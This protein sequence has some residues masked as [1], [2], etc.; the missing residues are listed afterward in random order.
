MCGRFY[1]DADAEFLL[2]YYRIQYEPRVIVE[3][4]IIYPTQS[5]PV[6]I[7][8]QGERRLGT[9]NWGFKIPGSTKPIINSRAETI[10]EKRL[11]KE[12]YE[13]R[14]CIVPASGFFEWSDLTGQKPKPKYQVS[15]QDQ[16]LMNMAGI[17]TKVISDNGQI[18][19]HFSIVTR[20]ANEDMKTIHPRMP[21]ILGNEA[22]SA[23]LDMNTPLRQID[24][25]LQTDI[26]RLTLIKEQSQLEFDID[27]FL[28]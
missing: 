2:N 25:L 10:H 16:S 21:L 18:S 26:G 19:W 17:Y 3:R 12:A 1:L 20:E 14:R 13:K 27:T 8:N 4:P 23:W 28:K 15:L 11:F 7:A 5:T 24:E 6:V 9:M 22:L